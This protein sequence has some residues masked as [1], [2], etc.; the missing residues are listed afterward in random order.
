L[1]ADRDSEIFMG[2]SRETG[3]VIRRLAGRDLRQQGFTAHSAAGLGQIFRGAIQPV[4]T[5]AKVILRVSLIRL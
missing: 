4:K 3:Q 1:L 5:T 2:V